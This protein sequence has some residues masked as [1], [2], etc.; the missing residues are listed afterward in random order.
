MKLPE[1]IEIEQKKYSNLSNNLL[2]IYCVMLTFASLYILVFEKADNTPKTS[3]DIFAGSIGLVFFG[4]IPILL[5]WFKKDQ[6][7]QL[8]ITNQGFMDHVS[9]Q[10]IAWEEIKA[11]RLTSNILFSKYIA[12]DLNDPSKFLNSPTK[13]KRILE[14]LN[15]RLTGAQIFMS[16]INMNIKLEQLY[17]ILQ[18]KKTPNSNTLTLFPPQSAQ[19]SQQLELLNHL[20][21]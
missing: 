19:E 5:F 20:H 10:F 6:K 7:I 13:L 12:I 21:F 9:G 3:V 1:T 2:I 11:I 4:I 14:V 18:E 16:T 17:A 15:Y 8:T